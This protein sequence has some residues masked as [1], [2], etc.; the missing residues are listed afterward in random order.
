MISPTGD[1][2][3]QED[4]E[5][6]SGASLDVSPVPKPDATSP[7]TIEDIPDVIVRELEEN[8]EFRALLLRYSY[9]G[10]LPPPELL[11]EYD[12]IVPGAARQIFE[13]FH[14]QTAHR[15]SIEKR[16]IDADIWKSKL[17]LVAGFVIALVGLVIA[18]DLG[19]SGHEWAAAV[20][21]GGTLASIVGSL[22]YATEKRGEELK[23]KR[24][25]RPQ[26]GSE[27]DDDQPAGQQRPHA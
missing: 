22:V 14:D 8:P 21:A 26:A 6:H 3:R 16:I 25:Q 15:I 19:R 12:Q 9:S 7:D 23:I 13:S 27:K 24:T 5:R 10:P 2:N 1:R 11:A 20:I 4:S 17:G 18:W